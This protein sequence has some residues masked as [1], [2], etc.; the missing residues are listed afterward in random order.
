MEFA[1]LEGVSVWWES[2]AQK[3]NRLPSDASIDRWV[4]E[5]GMN[6]TAKD[7]PVRF[8]DDTGASRTLKGKK[9]LYRS[10]NGN[11]LS[12]VG[13]EFKT[14]Q[15]RETIEF[16]RDLIEHAG[17]KMKTAGTLF[18]GTTFWAQAEVGAETV[19]KGTLN[20][21]SLLFAT[22]LDGSMSNTIKAVST[23]V[24][25]ANTLAYA[26]SEGGGSIY[27]L[28]HR[29]QFDADKAKRK[30]GIAVDGYLKFI[31]QAR[32]LAHMD[33]APKDAHAFIFALMGGKEEMG[34]VEGDKVESSAGFQKIMSLFNGAGRGMDLP[35]RK[36][37]AWGLVNAVTE[38]VDHHS[39]VRSED[40]RFM[41]AQFGS[42]DTLKSK[43]WNA[44][45][46]A[47]A[48]V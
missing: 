17:F 33:V 28:T 21:G 38:Y 23:E 47:A 39:R 22:A 10:D 30:L 9:I 42:G 43:A 18:G 40:N 26:M 7:R 24:V 36:G 37:T 5:A 6:W 1:A 45:L 13:S 35:G 15:P 44:A 14:V 12:V 46:A 32:E 25:C 41:S 29:S 31:H 3:V 48:L 11:G 16:Y 4:E 19:T 8:I 34:L 20:R 27:R 2:A